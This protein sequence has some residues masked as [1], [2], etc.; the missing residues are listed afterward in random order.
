[1]YEPRN[2]MQSDIV[3]LPHNK[4]GRGIG[5][6][7]VTAEKRRRGQRGEVGRKEG[8][9]KQGVGEGEEGRQGP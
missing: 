1:M 5:P 3:K 6:G 8:E 7:A 4:Q 2:K 9:G